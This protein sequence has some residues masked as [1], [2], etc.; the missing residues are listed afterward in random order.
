MRRVRS[1]LKGSGFAI[2]ILAGVNLFVLLCMCV[3]LNSYRPPRYGINVRPAASHFVIGSYDRALSHIITVTPG[4]TPRFFLED[5]E[6]TRGLDGM[7]EVLDAWASPTP[8]QVTV[9]IVCDEAVAVGTIQQ[10]ADKIMTRGYT[11]AFFGRP[12]LDE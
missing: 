8:A 5:R 6:V 12:A 4:E 3:L 10:L 1:N 11:C 7:D 2:I 9:I